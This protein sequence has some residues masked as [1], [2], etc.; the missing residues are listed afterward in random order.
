M[1]VKEETYYESERRGVLI[2]FI[3]VLN[4]NLII[5][6]FFIIIKFMQVREVIY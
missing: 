6:E 2:L 5:K 4:L 3:Y 1:K